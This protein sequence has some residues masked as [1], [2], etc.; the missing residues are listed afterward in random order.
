M[1]EPGFLSYWVESTPSKEP[2]IPDESDVYLAVQKR[3]HFLPCRTENPT[4]PQPSRTG[5][6]HSCSREWR[7]H[8]TFLCHIYVSILLVQCISLAP[9]FRQRKK[10]DELRVETFPFFPATKSEPTLSGPVIYISNDFCRL[11]P[12]SQ[13]NL[14]FSFPGTW[15]SRLCTPLFKKE[16]KK[17]LKTRSLVDSIGCTVGAMSQK[18][19]LFHQ[20]EDN[21]ENFLKESFKCGL[22]IIAGCAFL[23]GMS[24]YIPA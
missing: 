17:K 13:G 1:A 22:I 15:K 19:L 14:S 24:S 20:F 11:C 16:K 4:R 23:I 9:Y 7:K 2:G 6:G 10:N 12:D 8:N 21:R 5:R 3:K 18:I